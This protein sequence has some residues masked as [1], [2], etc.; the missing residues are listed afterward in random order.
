LGKMEIINSSI[1]KHDKIFLFLKAFGIIF[2][3]Q[4]LHSLWKKFSAKSLKGQ[5][6][7][8]TGAASGL[9]RLMSLRFASMGAKVVLWDVNGDGL[10]QVAKNIS[11]NGGT[12]HSYIVDLGSREDIYKTATK[13]KSEVGKVDIL[14]NNAGIVSGKCILDPQF[15]DERAA[16]T[17]KI[18]TEAHIWTTRA[19]VPEMAA[20]NKGHIVTLASAAG[21]VG[22]AGLT[23]YS[24]S[25]FGA[26]GFDEALRLEFKKKGLTGCHTTCVCP[27]Y[28]DTGMFAGAKSKWWF[29]PMLKQEWVVEQI[30]TGIVQNKNY[31]ILPSIVNLIFFGRLFF[32]TWF[33]DGLTA[34]LGVSNSMDDF[35]G[36][37]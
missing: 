14:V 23:D 33:A 18:N 12:C 17:L 1:Q 24:A 35:V 27:F 13:V 9:G 29:L 19:F 3:L 5:I 31:V 32:P 11:S 15:S 20:T 10:Q 26:F 30:I 25:K 4:F 22:T 28:I 21:I 8:V 37:Q 2:G 16:L 6:I 34:F 36:R 7:L